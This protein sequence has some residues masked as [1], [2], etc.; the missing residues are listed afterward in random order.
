MAKAKKPRA[1]HYT[2]EIGLKICE[3]L[4]S[5]QSLR[6]FC[7]EPGTPSQSM[8]YRWLIAHEDF[9]EKY[10][11][12][13]EVQADTLVDELVEIADAKTADV[14][15]TQRNRLR[16]DTRKWVAAKQRPVKYGERSEVNVNTHDQHNH[17]HV[18]VPDTAEWLRM[19]LAKGQEPPPPKLVSD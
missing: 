7:R 4:A 15:E 14:N 8:V 3:W 19:L 18:G 13:R 2:E 1:D 16:V 5:G 12:A 17:L 10:R 6:A 11:V 9:R